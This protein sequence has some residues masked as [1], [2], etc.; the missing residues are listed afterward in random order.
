VIRT[1]GL[2]DIALRPGELSRAEVGELRALLGRLLRSDT[3]KFGAEL[4]LSTGPAG[5]RSVLLQRDG[6]YAKITSG[7]QPYA[8]TREVPAASGGHADDPVPMSGTTTANP[9]YA[10]NGSTAVA[11]GTLVWMVPWFFSLGADGQNYAFLEAAA[12]AG[13]FTGATGHA[14][15]N[16]DF[17]PK[18]GAGATTIGGSLTFPEAGD[19]VIGGNLEFPTDWT[20]SGNQM[21][22]YGGGIFTSAGTQTGGGFGSRVSFFSGVGG[23]FLFGP[24]EYDMVALVQGVTNT[25]TLK[26]RAGWGVQPAGLGEPASIQISASIWFAKVK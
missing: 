14:T 20:P 15:L 5:M 18:G 16:P 9:A 22:S 24:A 13:G 6:F 21:V 19:Y 4:G 10:L 3:A 23:P 17:I 12:G 7:T 26:M 1:G 11:A 8:W 25:T 2:W